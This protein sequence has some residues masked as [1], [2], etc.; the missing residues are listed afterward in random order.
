MDLTNSAF[1]LLFGPQNLYALAGIFLY[2]RTYIDHSC[3]NNV[4]FKTRECQSSIGR[5]LSLNRQA[6]MGPHL[7]PQVHPKL[8]L[9]NKKH[10][11]SRLAREKGKNFLH[12]IHVL[13]RSLRH[14]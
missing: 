3:H 6:A 9:N 13:F 7:T 5:I 14:Y 10:F 8:F 1:I 11:V 4:G 12:H 2:Y